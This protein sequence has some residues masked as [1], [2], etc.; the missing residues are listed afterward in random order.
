MDLIDKI[1]KEWSWRCT[2]GYPQLDSEEDLRIL[3]GLF[4]INLTEASLT[5]HTEIMKEEEE[6]EI[7]V[8]DLMDLLKA[9]KDDLPAEFVKNLHTQIQGK[10]QGI[11]SKITKILTEK[12]MEESK[13]LVLTTAQSL[14][15][16]EKLL[17]YL[18]SESKPGLSE[19]RTGAGSGLVDFFVKQTNLPTELVQPIVDFS[20]IRTSKGV[21]KGEYGLALFMNDGAKRSV[22]DVDVEGVSIEIKADS[23]RLGE[24]HGNLKQLIESLEQITQIPEAV[25]LA[26]YL[27]Q[28]GKAN[29]DTATMTKV[30]EATNREF[31]DAFT[32]SDL[33]SIGEIRN[34][35]YGW[36]VDN[37]YATEPS[38]LIL[39]YMQGNYK[40][41]SREEFKVAVL[42]GEIKFKNDFTKSNKAPQLLGF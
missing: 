34:T 36:Y 31:Q 10:G 42:S 39:L 25:N 11:S 7:T 14:N 27:E 29:L 30:R 24:R 2:K 1:I 41:Y 12:G 32:G 37:F 22:G 33:T 19:L 6:P 40:V 16:E 35:L 18:E 20:S 17:Q 3:K 15:V 13:Y 28:I 8:D 4:N 38:D 9:R 21:G 26:K 23:A 5:T